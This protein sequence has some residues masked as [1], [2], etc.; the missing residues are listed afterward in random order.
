M[1]NDK[2]LLEM[3]IANAVRSSEE[4]NFPAGCIVAIN[5]KVIT[6]AV[7]SPYPGLLHA[8]SKATTEAFDSGTD[9]EKQH[10]T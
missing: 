6:S 2:Q 8:D 7:S 1:K 9:L 5:G 3:A 4:G 10:S